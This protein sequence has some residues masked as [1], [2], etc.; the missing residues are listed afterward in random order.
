M[1]EPWYECCGKCTG[2][3]IDDVDDVGDLDG[4]GI[5]DDVGE[6]GGEDQVYGEDELDG[7]GKRKFTKT[8]L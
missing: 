5:L 3:Y 2:E 4:V 6:L 8:W 7:V 1:G